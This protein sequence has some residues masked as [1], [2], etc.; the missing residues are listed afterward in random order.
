MYFVYIQLFS[1]RISRFFKVNQ[2]QWDFLGD[3][4]TWDD[5]TDEQLDFVVI[6]ASSHRKIC[7]VTMDMAKRKIFNIF[8]SPILKQNVVPKYVKIKNQF[9]QISIHDY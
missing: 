4:Y 7:I 1:Y 3:L 5:D 9:R 8:E 2:E 6:L